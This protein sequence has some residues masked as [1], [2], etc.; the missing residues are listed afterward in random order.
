[1]KKYLLP[2]LVFI[3][4]AVPLNFAHAQATTAL[5]INPSTTSLNVGQTATLTVRIADAADLFAYDITLHYDPSVVEIT[6]INN[7]SFLTG[8]F[9][10][11]QVLDKSAGTA[12]IAFTTIPPF[13]AQSGSGDLVTFKLK[14]KAGGS[15]LITI[16]NI[17]LLKKNATA[18]E[19]TAS[20][21]TVTV[22]GSTATDSPHPASNPGGATDT[23]Q[24]QKTSSADAQNVTPGSSSS[25]AEPASAGSGSTQLTAVPALR[26]TVVPAVPIPTP[27]GKSNGGGSS[28]VWMIP[29]GLALLAIGYFGGTFLRERTKKK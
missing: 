4:L 29:V 19:A 8:G 3:F 11:V 12:Q 10:A 13:S 17:Q 25:A 22:T 15:A 18:I 21:G 24:T 16:E 7:G 2:L 9:T 1:M 27:Q 5:S 14:V 26:E 23:G 28:L 6:S 20:S